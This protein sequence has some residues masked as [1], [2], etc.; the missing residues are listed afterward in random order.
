MNG[1][2]AAYHTSHR[3]RLGE[4]D[5]STFASD[6]TT[7]QHA[8]L[9][10]SIRLNNSQTCMD[11]ILIVTQIETV[12]RPNVVCRSATQEIGVQYPDTISIAT[13]QVTN[14]TVKLIHSVEQRDVVS[15]GSSFNAQV[16]VCASNG[17]HQSWEING[18]FRT[19]YHGINNVGQSRY[20]TH[21]SNSE[22]AMDSSLLLQ[23]SNHQYMSVF[24]YS[25]YNYNT[26]FIIECQSDNSVAMVTFNEPITE[27]FVTEGMTTMN[28]VPTTSEQ[29]LISSSNTFFPSQTL[30][31]KLDLCTVASNI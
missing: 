2:H 3:S 31:P 5:Y 12:E 23:K 26:N 27:A 9:L 24:V 16:L 11:A 19:G 29:Q 17:T 15:P 10:L 20:D 28:T 18:Q 4:A 6:S 14:G 1:E 8:S 13:N 7:V 25:D 22:V 30:P 21:P